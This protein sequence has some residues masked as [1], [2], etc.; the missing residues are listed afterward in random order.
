LPLDH[1][2]CAPKS[3][4]ELSRNGQ[5][6]TSHSVMQAST[7]VA[8]GVILSAFNQRA[9]FYSACVYLAQSNACLMVQLHQR[10]IDIS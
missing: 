6:L 8:L 4:Q 1:V 10:P 5:M 7:A 3:S 9:N 2:Q